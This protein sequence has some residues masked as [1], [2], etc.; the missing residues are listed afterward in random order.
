MGPLGVPSRILSAKLKNYLTFTSAAEMAQN[1]NL[2]SHLDPSTMNEVYHF[3]SIDNDTSVYGITGWPLAATSS[4]ML[5]N[6]AYLAHKMNSVYIPLRAEKVGDVFSLARQLNVK[7][8]SVTIPHKESVLGYLDS[9]D[10]HVEQIGACNTVVERDGS[11]YGFN[12]DWSGFSRAL[13]EFTGLKNLRG[14]KVA[15]IGAGGAAHAIAY[16]VK[17]LHG[18]ACV[19][20][21]TLTKARS[22]ADKYGFRHYPLTPDATRMLKK[23]SDIIIQTT[24]IGMNSNAPSDETNDPLYFYDFT[25]KEKL[26]DIVYVPETTPIM[27][28]AFQAGCKVCNGYEMLKYQGWEQFA[29]FTGVDYNDY[30]ERTEGSGRNN[31]N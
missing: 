7:G 20:N 2:L 4:P 24:S 13:L 28:R 9:V 11:W 3:K 14:K 19:F 16:A 31:G 29:L 18:D 30:N 22:L 26:F 12:T 6:T 5:H 17:K 27:S 1:V 10:E 21:R 8:F 23:Y 15:I 25:G